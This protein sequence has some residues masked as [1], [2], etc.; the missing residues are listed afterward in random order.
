MVNP[1]LFAYGDYG[2]YDDYTSTIGVRSH[3]LTIDETYSTYHDIN[4][5]G[6]STNWKYNYR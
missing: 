1:D 4:A 2:D 5:Y 6:Y 3:V